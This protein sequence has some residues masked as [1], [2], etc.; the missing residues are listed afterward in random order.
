MIPVRAYFRLFSG[1]LRPYRATAVLLS[2]VLLFTIALQLINPQLIALFIDRATE[3]QSVSQLV[4]I[5]IVF[6]AIAVAHQ[7]L[8][9]WSTYL[10]EKVGWGA[11][12]EM[13][14]D[15][16]DH[17]LR[18]DMGF[19][20]GTS[21][22]ELI[23]R[24]DGDVTA[25]SN[26]FSSMT[27]KVVG[28]SVLIAGILVLLWRE[29]WIVGSAITL[30]TLV[31][32]TALFRLHGM[33]V[34]WNKEV[35]AT[36]AELYGFIGEQ[37]DG[38]EDIE[39]NGATDFM[40]G[41]LD[42]IHKRWQPQVLRTWTGWAMMWATSMALYF[43]SLAITLIAGAW[44]YANG[45]MTLGSVFLIF[46]YVGM[47]NDPIEHIREELIDLQKAGA[48]IER[49]EELF[50]TSSVLVQRK[51]RM[52]GSGPLSVEFD[53]VK[54]SYNDEAG[55]EIVLDDVSFS[56]EPGSVVGLLGRTGS[57]K[58]TIARLL[59][60]MYEP[61]HGA[62]LIGG[63]ATWDI[64][65]GNLRQRV[66]IVT[67]E[68]Q[69]FRA[70]V[71]ENLTFFDPTASDEKLLEVIRQLELDEWLDSLP[72]GLD[73]HLGSGS[74]GLSA[75]QA[76]LL[77]FTRVFLRDPGVV[78]LD[79]ASS[80]LDPATEA[81]LERA[82][83]HLLEDRTAILIAHRLATVARADT[84][85]ILEDGKVI[86]YGNRRELEND[87]SSAFSQLLIAGMDEVLA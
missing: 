59:T 29:S 54:F 32:L 68:V 28:N 3:G 55:D 6:M 13:R 71:R 46:L 11:T 81:L 80:R 41:R 42:A 44:L 21:P 25:L 15:L 2:T 69:L 70:T 33:T 30:F 78:V 84:I 31:A 58:S 26:F 45:R 37:L 23:E 20:K 22:G 82:I 51:S 38:T 40:L 35:R 7:T 85:V 8:A 5:A 47:I 53:S 27:T 12:N 36:S 9:V 4:P 16:Q 72:Q 66:A 79:E 87:R 73:T 76:Q 83:D 62:V 24:I 39:A 19:H 61:Q 48:S 86:E 18:L 60:R 50:A 57:G 43:F 74:G 63:E 75:G 52:L 10:A 77:A 14:A 64:E 49:V 56:V 1:Y 34:P 67:Q 17:V 65:M